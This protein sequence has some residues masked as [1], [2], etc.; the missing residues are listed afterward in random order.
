[1]RPTEQFALRIRTWLDR[2]VGRSRAA[3]GSA[4]PEVV[5]EVV[6]AV[7]AEVVVAGQVEA[8]AVAER[9]V[10]AEVAEQVV[11]VAA[12]VVAAE[13]VAVAVAAA[14]SGGRIDESVAEVVVRHMVDPPHC[15]PLEAETA[16]LAVIDRRCRWRDVSHEPGLGRPGRRRRPRADRPSRFH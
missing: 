8:V 6:V 14:D 9:V 3:R 2:A 13:A 7:Q 12:E 16:G 1:M 5:A 15:V 10:V 11:V 4:P